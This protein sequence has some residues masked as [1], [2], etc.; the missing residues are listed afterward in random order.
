MNITP[1]STKE[2]FIVFFNEKVNKTLGNNLLFV[3]ENR[4][5]VVPGIETIRMKLFISE[6][7]I[8]SVSVNPIELHYSTIDEIEISNN[9]FYVTFLDR[10]Q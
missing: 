10:N 9:T 7:P 3:Y 8:A 1:K 2:E 6:I 5:R 4:K